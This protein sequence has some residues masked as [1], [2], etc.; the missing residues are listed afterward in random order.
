M[1]QRQAAALLCEEKVQG[2]HLRFLQR[3]D[4]A[5]LCVN[6]LV[7]DAAAFPRLFLL[8]R[9]H[10]WR[11]LHDWQ[12]IQ[13]PR[14]SPPLDADSTTTS[15]S[16]RNI[17]AW[18]KFRQAVV[19]H[20]KFSNMHTLMC[21]QRKDEEAHLQISTISYTNVGWHCTYIAMCTSSLRDVHLWLT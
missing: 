18:H 7:H 15:R 20:S 6:Q 14:C 2:I 9:C 12:G 1:W 21:M 11:L 8:F 17:F 16:G 4:V 13:H 3:L 19:L 5:S 10:C